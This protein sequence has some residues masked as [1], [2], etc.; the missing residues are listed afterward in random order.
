MGFRGSR[1]QI[2]PSRLDNPPLHNQLADWAPDPGLIVSGSA[3]ILSALPHRV[4]AVGT[5]TNQRFSTPSGGTYK[6]PRLYL[7]GTGRTADIE[8]GLRNFTREK[9]E[10]ASREPATHL[11]PAC[12]TAA[13]G[14]SCGWN[15]MT[16]VRRQMR[17][18]EVGFPPKVP[19]TRN[20]TRPWSGRWGQRGPAVSGSRC[21]P[22]YSGWRR[23]KVG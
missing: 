14:R 7:I 15:W 21:R 12:V 10:S 1:V 23:Q 2:P 16:R 11:A 3:P 8:V 17:K 4:S 5:D 6:G 20:N 18:V 13:G 19:R 22:S 9:H